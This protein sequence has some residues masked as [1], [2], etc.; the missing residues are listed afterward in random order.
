MA[1]AAAQ[2]FAGDW[3][4]RGIATGILISTFGCLNG[5]ILSSPWVYYAVAKDGLFFSPF[6]RTHPERGTPQ[7][8]I[9]AQAVWASV[10]ALSGTYDK[11]FTYVVFV[12]WLF[13]S[14]AVVSVYIF[15]HREGPPGPKEYRTW[16]YPLTPGL[17]LLAALG[18]LANTLYTDPWPAAAGLAIT[19]LGLPVFIGFRK[20]VQ[21]RP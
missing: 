15:R 19:A 13:Y 11:L 1:S 7:T 4:A 20:R 9:W 18:I 5:M 12:S 14:L 8:A 21:A 16:G 6:A 10:L 3:G 2:L 17:F